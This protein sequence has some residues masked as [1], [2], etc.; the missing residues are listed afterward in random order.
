MAIYTSRFSNP[1]LRKGCYTAVR[2]AVGAP[3]WDV[4]YR[5][6]GECKDLM[7]FGLFGKDNDD[8]DAEA[9]KRKYFARLD[10]AGV[11]KIRA[12]LAHFESMGKD[13]VLLCWEDIR[14]GEIDWCHRTMFAQWWL[15]RTG[16]V[17]EELS[18]P[19]NIPT[20]KAPKTPKGSSKTDKIDSLQIPLFEQLNF[21]L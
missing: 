9:F 13:V 16:E 19:T 2:I 4:G 6:D 1:E 5:L 20:L 17:I 15:E 8:S 12:Q 21:S 14:K 11:N 10:K 18:D 7:P 3:R